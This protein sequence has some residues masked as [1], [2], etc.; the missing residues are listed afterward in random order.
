MCNLVA[1]VSDAVLVA[2]RKFLAEADLTGCTVHE[3][4]QLAGLPARTVQHRLRSAGTSWVAEKTQERERRLL[5][6]LGRPKID[7]PSAA[8]SCGFSGTDAFLR[9]FKRA[10][11][12]TYTEYRLARQQEVIPW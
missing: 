12:K 3:F 10:M 11:G 7:I 4:A 6:R 5:N 9:F 1:G 8:Q 2:V